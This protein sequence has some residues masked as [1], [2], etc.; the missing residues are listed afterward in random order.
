MFKVNDIVFTKIK[1]ENVDENQSGVIADKKFTDDGM[2][3]YL[4]EFL[5]KNGDYIFEEIHESFL[6][7]ELV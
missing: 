7:T 1:I 3:M 4:V 5:T 2:H 6:S